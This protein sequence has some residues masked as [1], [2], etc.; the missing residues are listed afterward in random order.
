MHCRISATV[1]DG[2][3]GNEQE[4]YS[5][6]S[7]GF[8]EEKAMVVYYSISQGSATFKNSGLPLEI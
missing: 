8:T 1:L 4:S 2:G 6:I 5:L 7:V 3:R